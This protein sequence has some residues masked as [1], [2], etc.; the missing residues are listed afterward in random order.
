MGPLIGTPK[1]ICHSRTLL[2]AT[3]FSFSSTSVLDWAAQ[4]L[5]KNGDH[6]IIIHSIQD[7]YS[8]SVVYHDDVSYCSDIDEATHISNDINFAQV[9]MESAT[10]FLK[11]CVYG[12]EKS[13]IASNVTDYSIQKV[14]S[15][16][17]PGPVIVAKAEEYNP[18][19]IVIGTNGRTMLS[20]LIMGSVSSYVSCH[21]KQ[22]PIIMIQCHSAKEE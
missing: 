3:D 4:N 15:N 12:F 9:E 22:C 21:F 10:S 20:E 1:T 13:L 16:G 7:V 8:G 5:T 11:E 2:I 17:P 19:M 6:I 14:V 18:D